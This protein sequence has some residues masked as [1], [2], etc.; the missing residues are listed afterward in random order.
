MGPTAASGG[1]SSITVG[2]GAASGVFF[3]ENDPF[4]RKQTLKWVAAR[5]PAFFCQ[6]VVP[7]SENCNLYAQAGANMCDI[8][9]QH[10][11]QRVIHARTYAPY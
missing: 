3:S 7:F 11:A 9:V 6:K 10:A 2:G 1:L 4:Y 5:P 8:F